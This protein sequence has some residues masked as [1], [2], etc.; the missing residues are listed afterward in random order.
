MHRSID[1]IAL[2][3][4]HTRERERVGARLRTLLEAGSATFRKGLAALHLA[5]KADPD[6]RQP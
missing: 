3:R 6:L 4:A 1:C 5:S 2:R